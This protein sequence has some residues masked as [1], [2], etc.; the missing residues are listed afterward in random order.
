MGKWA[1]WLIG[2]LLWG[3]PANARA[4]EF[5]RHN[6]DSPGLNAIAA[7]GRIEADDSESLRR[8]LKTL[9]SK[10]NTAVY[11]SSPAVV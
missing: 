5:S 8:Y 4:L 1:A 3:L 7:A 11:L 6:A 10:P 2:I 9:P